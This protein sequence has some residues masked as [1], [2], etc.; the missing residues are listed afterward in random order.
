MT[1][2]RPS[3]SDQPPLDEI[4]ALRLQAWQLN[5][6]NESIRELTL[7]QDQEQIL[8]RFFLF[9]SGAAGASQGFVLALENKGQSML[10]ASRGL[11]E[12]STSTL[13]SSSGQIHEL[14]F[15][16]LDNAQE[17]LPKQVRLVWSNK[18]YNLDSG[19]IPWPEQTR[20]LIQWTLSP[21]CCGFIGLGPKISSEKYSMQETDFLLNMAE[22]L[23]EALNLARWSARANQLNESLCFRNQELDNA[24]FQA[25]KTQ[26]DLDRQLFHFKSLSETARELS[27]IF[28][29][30]KLLDAFLLMSQGAMSSRQAFILLFE[31]A[32]NRVSFSSRGSPVLDRNEVD[33]TAVRELILSF[34]PEPSCFA[35][36]DFKV[37]P[38]YGSHAHR[39]VP[40]LPLDMGMVFSLDENCFGM[41]GF[42]RKIDGSDFTS[43]EENLLSSLTRTFLLS[44]ENVLSFEIIQKLNLDLGR[45]NYELSRTVEELRETKDRVN[46]L[47]KARAG[48]NNLIQGELLRTEKM[49]ILD[50]VFIFGL[51]L[52]L[53]L[54]YNLSSP[55]GTSPVPET[56][57][58]PAPPAIDASWAALKHQ[59][60][61]AVFVDARPREFYSRERIAQA[62]NLPLDLFD[63]VYMMKFSRL[64]P[65]QEIIVYGRS[66][67]RRY[68]SKVAHEL[69]LRGHQQ[70]RVLAGG[71]REWKKLNMPVEP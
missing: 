67:S 19:P 46:V 62:L 55:G 9:L 60:Q 8:D 58:F 14:F 64:D 26:Q 15:S 22:V 20:V 54:T 10:L 65:E 27:S 35:L 59:N 32:E 18:S 61:A 44:L 63:F 4:Q 34:Y 41:V 36:S 1:D 70:V 47:Q 21:D 42:S 48:L 17:I 66:I 25:Q 13:R 23:M 50:F 33:K 5:I 68:D 24:L 7:I 2:N 37:Q 29:R 39:R 12:N 69:A 53:G 16:H 6:L 40:S 71:I 38:V 52:V 45:R 30:T 49:H 31:T 3:T 51:T 56:W 28:D 57:T 11:T 43:V